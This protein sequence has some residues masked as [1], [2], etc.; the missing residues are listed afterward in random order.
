LL[1]D[2]AVNPVLVRAFLVQL[3]SVLLSSTQAK[4]NKAHFLS[5]QPKSS[6]ESMEVIS[7]AIDSFLDEIQIEGQLPMLADALVDEKDVESQDDFF[8][9]VEL[10]VNGTP[11]F[12]QFS[13]RHSIRSSI[14]KRLQHLKTIAEYVSC[15]LS[16]GCEVVPEFQRDFLSWRV[17]ALKKIPKI[18]RLFKFLNGSLSADIE[19]DV[20]DTIPQ[21]ELD[22]VAKS[23]NFEVKASALSLN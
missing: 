13:S 1:S 21:N 15:I 14:F 11:G 10:L 23:L 19:T 20:D 4:F 22:I 5:L 2:E 17:G 9:Q 18:E 6:L 3:E 16:D 8:T 12:V 7:N